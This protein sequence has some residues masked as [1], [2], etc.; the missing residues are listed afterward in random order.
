VNALALDSLVVGRR[1]F[2]AGPFDLSCVP[3]K[4]VAL[5]GPNGGGKT[6]LLATL[7]GLIPP[8]G[9]RLELPGADRPALLPAPGAIDV[10][11][12]A[13]HVVALGRAA[14]SRWSPTLRRSD[15]MAARAA[16]DR[17]GIAELGG[18]PFDQLSSGQRQLVLLARLFVQ[19]APV[20]LLDEPTAM[21]DPAQAAKVEAAI[22][23]L[24]R[25]GR[26]VV[27]ATHALAAASLADIVV[28]VG[29]PIL[30]GSPGDVL[31]D[32]RLSRLYGASLNVCSACGQSAAATTAA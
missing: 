16:L 26:I 3:G 18:R 24:A 1:A 13:E 19:E 22:G 6:T 14:R 20:C 29:D 28:T 25:E 31:T 11:F 9:G 30:V 8:L 12:A 21:L 5:V 27:F 7:A 32:E 15:R 23:A 10:G 4:V 17:L 2:R